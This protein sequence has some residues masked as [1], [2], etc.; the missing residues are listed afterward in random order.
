[1]PYPRQLN[2]SA[3]VEKA[4]KTYL[5]TQLRDHF[6]ERGDHIQD[7]MNWQRDY[8]VKPSTEVREFP[9]RGASN[10]IIPL[11]AIAVEAVHAR[12]MQTLFAIKPMFSIKARPGALGSQKLG[13]DLQRVEQPLEKYMDYEVFEQAKAKKPINDMLL[14]QEKYGTGIGKV[15]YEKRVRRA[16]RT[17][18]TIEQ[19][20]LVV[21]KDG[22]T[23]DAVPNANFLMPFDEQD[24]QT[25]RWVGEE[26]TWS[27]NQIKIMEN[28]GLLKDG[29]HKDLEMWYTQ[30]DVPTPGASGRE[31]REAQEGLE[32]RTVSFPHRVHTQEI[33]L[34]FDV[35]EDEQLEEIQVLFH[36]DS[37]TI[38]SVRYNWNH[39]LHRPYRLRPYMPVEHRWA[40]IGI[41]K[42]NDQFQKEITTIHRQRLDNATLANMRMY[43]ISK[44]SQYGPK[45]PVFPGKMWFLDDLEQIDS[46]EMSEIYPSAYSNEQATLNYQQQR[47]GV[48]DTVLGIPQSGTPGT[49]TGDLARIQES[50]KKFDFTFSNS[51]EL[52]GE[53][54]GDSVVTIA[55]FGTKNTAWFELVEG[56]DLVQQFFSLG[57]ELIRDG[58]LV[59]IFASGSQQNRLL[60][61]QDWQ[62]VGGFL[63]QYYVGLVEIARLSGDQQ[64]MSTII[65]R[66]L[67][68][69]TEAMKQILETFDIRNIERFIVPELE[70]G[71]TNGQSPIQVPGAARTGGAESSPQ[72]SQEP[73]LGGLLALI[74]SLG[75]GGP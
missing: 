44:L 27:E 53:L 9:F 63:Q 30:L 59:E 66:A 65:Q 37:E 11:T 47:T 23:V 52:L 13:F 17:V 15:G 2:L 14:E 38:L 39:D 68:G 74:Q 54:L 8:W 75:R 33:W 43:K 58:I 71:L 69:S 36:M 45:E 73:G 32:G 55:Q 1:M 67:I 62:Q 7:L 4:L 34:S 22:V 25:A 35:D 31:F 19:D 24:P 12:T 26:H 6:S 5:V 72:P 61:R 50:Q 3:E 10:I 18:G 16:V 49:A 64:L 46:L 56:G 28:S 40:G 60:D 51:K 29:A 21:Q 48:N 57:P 20:Y 42:Q 41:C 70:A